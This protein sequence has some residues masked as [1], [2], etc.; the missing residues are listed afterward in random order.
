MIHPLFKKNAYFLLPYMLFLFAGGLILAT[1]AK[2]DIHLAVNAYHDSL[3]DTLFY[4]A[5]FLGDGFTV[6]IFALALL[7]SKYWYA[8]VV[9]GANVIAGAIT[10]GLK[11]LFFSEEVRPKEFFKDLAELYFVPGVDNHLYYSFPSGHTTAAFAF[12]LSLA[13][14]SRNKTVKIVLFCVALFVAYSRVYLSQ[15]FFADIYAGSIIGST[16]ALTV[17]Y[18][19]ERYRNNNHPWTER[20][21]LNSSKK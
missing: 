6:S 9:G 2:A 10:Q 14:I 7:F 16:V 17:Y 21:L 12:Y 15:H 1:Q 3:A 8:V 4:Y 20:S 13:L 11:H 5:T 19:V 18:F